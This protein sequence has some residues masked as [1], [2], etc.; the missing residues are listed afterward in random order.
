MEPNVT[1]MDWEGLITFG[2]CCGSVV[3]ITH[4][5]EQL[6][7]ERRAAAGLARA[8]NDVEAGDPDAAQAPVVTRNAT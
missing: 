4:V 3:T 1:L 2:A 8:G 6:R 7:L 5:L